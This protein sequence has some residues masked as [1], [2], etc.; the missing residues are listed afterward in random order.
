MTRQEVPYYVIL[1]ARWLALPAW[2]RYG[3]F[4]TAAVGLLI[5]RHFA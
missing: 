1:A 3:P 2:V 4:W 5:W